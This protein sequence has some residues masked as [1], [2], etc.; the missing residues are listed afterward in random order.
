[1]LNSYTF[2]S[3][4]EI[5]EIIQQAYQLRLND[6]RRALELSEHARQLALQADYQ[7]GLAYSLYLACVCRIS[8]GDVDDLLAHAYQAL[9]LME[10]LQDMAGSAKMYNLL[11]LIYRRQNQPAA[12]LEML[13]KALDLRRELDDVMGQTA[14]LN[15]IANFYRSIEQPAQAL[16]C[17]FEALRLQERTNDPETGAYVLNTIAHIYF[18]TGEY[19]RALEYAQRGLVLNRHTHDRALD[20][21][22]LTL[23]STINRALNEPEQAIACLQASLQVNAQTG[24]L[25]DEGDTRLALGKLYQ[26]LGQYALAEQNLQAALE[27][28]R[29]LLY[30]GDIA[31]VL[32]AL[33][34]LK[35]QQAD[36]ASARAYFEQTIQSLEN[37]PNSELLRDALLSLTEICETQGEYQTALKYHRHYHRVC[38]QVND[39]DRDHSSRIRQLTH[40]WEARQPGIEDDVRQEE[41]SKVLHALQEADAEK[42]G[43][44]SRLKKQA[45]LLEQL[46][47]E[48]G[49]TGIANR[50]WLDLKLAQEFERAR[51][52]EHPL[53]VALLDLDDFKQVNDRFSHQAG[54]AVLVQMATLMRQHF[55]S[56]DVVGRYGGEE[57]LVVLVETD[58]NSAWIICERFRRLVNEFD[59]AGLHAGLGNLTV[60]IGL[61]GLESPHSEE[62]KTPAQLLGRADEHLYRAK[63]DGKNRVCA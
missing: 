47:R 33:A 39:S 49:L 5:D 2:S 53:T 19:E 13:N 23:L 27:V 54:D 4:N 28:M 10:G 63:R 56:V 46:A 12:A 30:A 44:L 11:G 58:I 25:S 9:S 24:N 31:K 34:L 43:L 57:F 62:I 45:E 36:F 52:F 59:W 3:S 15:N 14:S 35:Q 17:L 38:L 48:D 6:S 7:K 32:Y 51:R 18:D 29:R 40:E 21:T 42:A 8:L 60:S 22:L 41:L 37:K 16:E 20:S 1:M 55:R 61:S 26:D 50:R